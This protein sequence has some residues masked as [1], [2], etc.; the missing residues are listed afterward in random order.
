MCATTE[1]PYQSPA[2]FPE[3]L[4]ISTSWWTPKGVG[5]WSPNQVTSLWW[6]GSTCLSLAHSGLFIWLHF[7]PWSLGRGFSK[8]LDARGEPKDGM[9][10]PAARTGDRGLNTSKSTSVSCWASGQAQSTDHKKVWQQIKKEY[11][12]LKWNMKK[13]KIW[14]QLKTSPDIRCRQGSVVKSDNHTDCNT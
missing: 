1:G 12:T 3:L 10:T 2:F 8:V 13:K 11:C 9:G 6:I 4:P 14:E 7:G 5:G